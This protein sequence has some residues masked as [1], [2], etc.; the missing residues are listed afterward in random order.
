MASVGEIYNFIDSFAPFSSALEFDNVGLLV[1]SEKNKV[2]KAV[3]ALD[4]TCDV[5]DFAHNNG[6][7]LIISHHPIIFSPLKA[8]PT[9]S[10]VYRAIH[11]GIDIISAHTNLDL[12]PVLGVNT[13]LAQRLG[14]K[15]ISFPLEGHPLVLGSLE[16]AVTSKEFI[17]LVKKSLGSF[18]LRHSPCDKLIQKVAVGGGA[19]GEYAG[20]I[21]QLGADAFVTGELKH[22]EFICAHELG[23][24]AVDAGHFYTENVVIEP[25]CRKLSERFT[26]V[27]FIS[28][29]ICRTY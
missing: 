22:H 11:C 29:D 9:D 6:A 25:L 1:G 23:Y 13:C 15:D 4:V 8:I 24:L 18:E 27:E 2:T 20:R 17:E 5:V 19:C 12:S 10:V 28:S 16:N 3:V 21:P 26:D 14:L 7:Q